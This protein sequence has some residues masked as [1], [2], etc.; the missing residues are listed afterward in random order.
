MKNCPEKVPTE[1][2]RLLRPCS[3]SL[4]IIFGQEDHSKRLNKARSFFLLD[5]HCCSRLLPNLFVIVI[6]NQPQGIRP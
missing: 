2:S 4:A 1:E 6:S 5:S 3:Y